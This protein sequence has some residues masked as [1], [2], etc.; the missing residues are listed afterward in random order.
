MRTHR[1]G[2]GVAVLL[3]VVGGLPGVAHAAAGWSS[4]GT[5]T[6]NRGGHTATLLSDGRVLVAGGSDRSFY[7]PVPTTELY[8]PATNNW[9]DGARMATARAS[10]TA[11]LLADGRVLV[12]GGVSARSPAASAELYDPATDSWASAGNMATARASHAAAPLSDGRVLVTGG[13]SPSGASEATAE[14]YDPAD[15]SWSSVSR[16]AAGRYMHTAT[17][18]A[19]GRVLLAGGV[20][21]FGSGGTQV[22]STELYDPRAD[23]WAHGAPM[24]TSR[25]A[26]T[27]TVLPD[28]RVLVT[29]GVERPGEF[30]A[31]AEAYDPAADRWTGAGAMSIPRYE[32]AAA[33]LP[34][35]EVLVS[36]GGAQGG[37]LTTAEIYDV[38]AN[39]WAPTSSMSVGRTGHRATALRDGRVLVTGGGPT[40]GPTF[41][42]IYGDPVPIP[43]EA[44][45]GGRRVQRLG[46]W[47][48]VVVTCEAG[49][50]ACLVLAKGT[51]SVPGATR[52]FKLRPAGTRLP[53]GTQAKLRLRITRKAR[54][55][56]RGALRANRRVRAKLS[57]RVADAA[58]EAR[59]LT[60]RIRLRLPKVRAARTP[61]APRPYDF[62]GDGRQELAVGVPMW[63]E[64]GHQ[65]SGAVV[66]VETSR[67]GLATSSTF[68]TE[69][70]PGI[71]GDPEFA[72]QFGGD[73]ASGDFNGDGYADL[74]IAVP[75]AQQGGEARSGVVV[76]YGARGGLDPERSSYWSDPGRR[77]SPIAAGR[78]DGDRYADLAVDSLAF[79][80]GPPRARIDIVRGGP[81]GLAAEHSW[82]LPHDGTRLAIA[83]VNRDRRPEIV[84][85]GSDRAGICP[86]AA[87]GPRKCSA[88]PMPSP[89]NSLAIG[90]VTGGA[91]RE[92]AVGLPEEVGGSVY[93]FRA[94]RLLGRPIRIDQATPGVPGTGA[95]R[96]RFGHSVEIGRIGRARRPALVVGAPGDAETGSATLLWGGGTRLPS[97]AGQLIDQETPGVP[98]AGEPGDGFGSDVLL[99]DHNRD[100]RPDLGVGAPGEDDRSGHVTVL[101]GAR[102]G[103]TTTGAGVFGPAALGYAPLPGAEFGRNLGHP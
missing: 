15:N 6:L 13:T 54:R 10:H 84:F 96:D 33:P 71:P 8:D 86:G 27:A 91:K 41:P 47:V 55:A 22:G 100:G 95:P 11:T 21:G 74:A 45:L 3:A 38:Q 34:G 39:R 44:T 61:A 78:L 99:S 17:A 4:A 5:M 46:R 75:K 94:G 66:V 35:G 68:L 7:S 26:H 79:P 30:T 9:S 97:R 80:S 93:V 53:N 88:V 50:E 37:G 77:A 83:D 25:G 67:S 70:T 82:T 81:N 90:D 65:M 20:S 85:G 2:M 48:A 23:R 60:R 56:A 24:S 14:V 43:P 101:Y 51:L 102:R 62:D 18:L 52:A 76:L 28:D 73:L 87:S 63:S 12:T 49:D 31:S 69:A 57:V 89:V 42:E 92:I 40:S 32:H 98:G 59:T 58:G 16:M 103:L 36:G 29:G 72:S 64:G 1:P 19:D